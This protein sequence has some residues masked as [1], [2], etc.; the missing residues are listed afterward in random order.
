MK[1][2]EKSVLLPHRADQIYDLVADIERYPEFLVGC[3][4]AE[5]L[6]STDDVVTA[7]L[8]LS[9]AGIRFEFTTRNFMRRPSSI[10]L[11]LLDG[12]F[13][14]FA[15]HWSFCSLGEEACKCSPRLQFEMSSSALGIGLAKLFDKVSLDFVDALVLRSDQILGRAK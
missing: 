5:I 12:P 13:D 8:K 2:I 3:I 1:V 10:E 7:T 14:Q 9:R 11:A 4:G 6:T 15:G